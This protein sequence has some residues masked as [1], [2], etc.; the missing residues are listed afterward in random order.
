MPTDDAS[1]TAL[2]VWAE[3]RERAS[4]D[5]WRRAADLAR[6]GC[7]SD[8]EHFGFAARLLALRAMEDRARAAALRVRT[9]PVTIE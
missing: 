5:L 6:G 3:A 2:E 9:E 7:R 1:A 4:A 8:A